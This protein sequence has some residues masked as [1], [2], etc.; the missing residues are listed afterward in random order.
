MG[1]HSHSDGRSITGA[2]LARLL[3]RL[4]LDQDHAARE[5]ERMRRTL[6]RFFDWRG[7]APADEC[8]DRTLDRLARKL[9]ETTVDDVWSYVHGIARMVLHEYRR[10]PAFSPIDAAGHPPAPQPARALE[11]NEQML[12]CLDR[13]LA[14]L[15]ADSRSLILRYYQGNRGEKVSN[16][17]Q[18]AAALALSENALRSR[19]QRVRDRLEQCIRTCASSAGE[20]TS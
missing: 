18:L 20:K 19:V 15:P 13:C 11:E 3:A 9:D 14:D 16:R 10:Q 5:Y 7:A 1:A 8:A 12:Q 2:D 17:R 6:I 4:G